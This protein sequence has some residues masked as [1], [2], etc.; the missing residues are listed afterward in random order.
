MRATDDHPGWVLTLSRRCGTLDRLRMAQLA[1][2]DSIGFL[3]RLLRGERSDEPAGIPREMPG[4]DDVSAGVVPAAPAQTPAAPAQTPAAPA[5]APAAACPYSAKLLDP[6]PERSRLCPRCRRRIVVRRVGGRLV[7]LTEQAQ[8]VFE[9]EQ[10]RE[11]NERAWN[12]ERREWLALAKS[13]EAPANRIARLA[14][15]P[16]SQAV[17]TA[18]KGLYLANAE[19]AV[20]SARRT[21]SWDKVASVRRAQAAALY[22]ASGSAV[23]PSE[24]IVSLHREW[25]AAALRALLRFG[26]AQAELVGS[27]CCPICERDNGQ[28]FLIKAELRG[29]R[30][31]HEGC[32]R[33]LCAC[34]WWPVPGAATGSRRGRRRARSGSTATPVPATEPPPTAWPSRCSST[35]R[36]FAPCSFRPQS[37]FLGRWNWWA[38]GPVGRLTARHG[39]DQMDDDRQDLRWTMT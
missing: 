26:A 6:P 25:S 22:R 13:V 37:V 15:A 20:R 21:K 36:S 17:V 2:R 12:H 1:G 35:P 9:S 30:L 3:R 10:Q 34:D 5:R 14:A 33:G 19:R 7:L 23:P 39:F 31:P 24:E 11:I 16:V 4:L 28:R 32:P 18:S 38:P 27:G 8:E 29:Q